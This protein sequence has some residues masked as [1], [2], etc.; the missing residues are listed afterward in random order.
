MDS[1]QKIIRFLWASLAGL[2]VLCVA[3]FGTVAFLAV[4]EGT[5]TMRQVA[6]TYMEG[7][8][9]QIQKHF[10]TLVKMRITQ[11]Q[12]ITQAVGPETVDALDGTVIRRLTSV[13]RLRE[14]THLFLYDTEGTATTIYG[15]P[16]TV[17]NQEH[18]LETMNS[19]QTLVTVGK[20]SDGSTVLLY[21]L[22]VGY[23]DTEGY[24]LPDGGR[25]TA[26]VVGL[27][28]RHLSESLSLGADSTMIV[29]HVVRPDGSFVIDNSG[30][31]GGDLFSR[32]LEN[33]EEYGDKDI[34]HKVQKARQAIAAREPYS[35]ATTIHGEICHFYCVPMHSTDW[36]MVCMMPH[37]FLD[38]ALNAMTDRS[39]V[40]AIVS[41]ALLI[42]ATMLIFFAYIRLSRRQVADLDRARKE[43]MDASRAKSEFLSNMSHD[44]RTPMNAI[45]GM[46]AI[47]AANPGDEPKVQECLRK[48]TVSSRHLL[49]LINDVL[50]MSKIESGRLTLNRDVI[51]LR[52]VVDGL[53]S[54]V[55]PQVKAKEQH[56]DVFIDGIQSERIYADSVRMGQVLMNLLSNALKYTP[57][58]GSVTVTVAQEASPLGESHVRTHFWVRDTGIGMSQEFQKRIFHA[59]EREDNARVRQIEGTG[60]GMAITKYIVDAAGGTIS[61]RSELGKGTEFHVAFDAERRADSE[62]EML[63]PA[64]DVLVVDDDEPLCRGAVQALGEIGVQAEW[65]LNGADAVDMADRRHQQHRDYYIILLDWKMPGMSGIETARALRRRI[66]EDTPILLISA[67]DWSDI[68]DEAR[69]AGIS[70]FLEKPLFKSTLYHGLSRFA[71]DR[72]APEPVAETAPDFTGRRLLV[73]EDNALN[74]EITSELLSTVGFTLD[75]AENGRQCV[76]MFRDSAAGSY[77]AIL[78]DLRMPVMNGYE[79][80]AAIRAEDRPDAA[81][82]PIIAMTADAFAEDIQKCLE[83]GMN[84]HVPKPLDLPELL[85]TLQKLLPKP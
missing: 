79:A 16:V 40:L 71:A 12:A 59:F 27:P 44:I 2:I 18:F 22:S 66:G 7:M 15:N 47:A 38:D 78:M 70:G 62:A 8:S 17:E 28:I 6:D 58:G 61:V 85:R 52:E 10:G 73:A 3:V 48:I 9:Q 46:T 65:A 82:I 35:L 34:A 30:R 45:I 56:F 37:G 50:D 41:C 19:G 74:W 76:E 53:V 57:P 84:C 68:E 60:L 36:T 54:I 23:P 69:A 64:W 67:Y 42:A 72:P 29:T 11:V 83:C 63:L 51:S 80:T 39:I 21:G 14:F 32:L 77:D 1:N 49:G 43:A 81:E 4:R 75:W 24:P 5:D 33:G 31:P 13:G 20:E 25:C 55:Q 26:L